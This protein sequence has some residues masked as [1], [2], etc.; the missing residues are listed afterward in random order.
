[1]LAVFCECSIN[2]GNV[3]FRRLIQNRHTLYMFLHNHEIVTTT[4]LTLYPTEQGEMF[5]RYVYRNITLRL[6]NR[7]R[8]WYV[9]KGN[10][11]IYL[12]VFISCF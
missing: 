10:E 7:L 11:N 5:T 2:V 8:I 3:W 6:I 12:P 9:Q 4:C 1:M